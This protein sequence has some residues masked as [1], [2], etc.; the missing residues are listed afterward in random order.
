MAYAVLSTWRF[1]L[2][3]NRL[4]LQ[5]LKE[6]KPGFEAALTGV[7]NVEDNPSFR[8]V[9]YG[10]RPDKTG[11]VRLDGGFMDG[12]TLHFGAVASLEGFAS[13][14]KIAC[15]L[16]KGDYNNFL[17]GEGAAAWAKAHGFKE[18]DNLTEES[19]KQ[20]EEQGSAQLEKLSAWENHDTVCFIVLDDSGICVSTS[21]SGL[22]MK[23][24]GR[25][26][27]TPLAGSG[28]YADS[29]YGAAA[30]TGTGEEIIKGALSYAAVMYLRLGFSPQE[31]A[32]KAVVELHDELVRRNGHC[33]DMALI[34]MDMQGNYGIGTNCEFPFVYG[35]DQETARLFL[36]RFVN[37]QV[38]IEEA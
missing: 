11:H 34:V 3:G 26:G 17:V 4:A 30:A 13:P 16:S 23:E 10:G 27:D 1:S 29:G 25:V 24:A 33:H 2:E 6:G 5:A 28:F 21:T 35:S 14:S 18:R 15:A 12:N 36:S 19:R 8:S 31:A 32:E 22:F 9:G 38:I 7:E 37:H 20:Y